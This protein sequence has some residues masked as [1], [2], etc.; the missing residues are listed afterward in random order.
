MST[1]VVYFIYYTTIVLS[2]KKKYSG[3]V[4]MNYYMDSVFRGF[5]II[6]ADFVYGLS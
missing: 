6:T 4:N 1:E 5:A 3:T 2:M